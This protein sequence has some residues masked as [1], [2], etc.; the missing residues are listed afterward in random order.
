LSASLRV[1]T[2]D[3]GLRFWLFNARTRIIAWPECIGAGGSQVELT[4]ID[5]TDAGR[6][7]L[8]RRP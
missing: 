2:R 3:G 6:A 5:I 8:K 1:P 7:P 4:R